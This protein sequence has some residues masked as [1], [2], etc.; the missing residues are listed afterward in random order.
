[1]L[2]EHL[3]KAQVPVAFMPKSLRRYTALM[4]PSEAFWSKASIVSIVSFSRLYILYILFFCDAQSAIVSL[5]RELSMDFRIEG[6]QT[7]W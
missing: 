5:V 7:M 4:W 1:M 3:N 2:T 6:V